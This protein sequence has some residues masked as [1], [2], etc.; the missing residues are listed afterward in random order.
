MLIAGGRVVYIPACYAGKTFQTR[1]T[2]K[3]TSNIK[4][5][6]SSTVDLYLRVLNI[7]SLILFQFGHDVLSMSLY[8]SFHTISSDFLCDYMTALWVSMIEFLD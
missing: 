6:S 8:A 7:G 1:F 5:C 3:E 4:H 2:Y